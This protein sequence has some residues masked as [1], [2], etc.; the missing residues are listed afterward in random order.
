MPKQSIKQ[1]SIASETNKQIP[2][3]NQRLLFTRKPQ[4]TTTG[5]LLLEAALFAAE[6]KRFQESRDMTACD[7]A[8]IHLRRIR[9]LSEQRQAE[10]AMML[11]NS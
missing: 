1:H 5:Q 11:N 2:S 3:S 10:L 8:Q 9:E 6:N 4:R 7:R